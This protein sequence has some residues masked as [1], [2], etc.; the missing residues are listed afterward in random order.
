METRPLDTS[1]DMWRQHCHIVRAMD[2]ESRVRVAIELSD[3]VREL[4]IAGLLARNP[5]W[6]RPE[7]IRDLVWRTAG[8]DLSAA[9]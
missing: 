1:P 4:Q 3:A 9:G 5:G 6:S 2:E 8:V 7:A